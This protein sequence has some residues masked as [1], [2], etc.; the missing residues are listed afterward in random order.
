MLNILISLAILLVSCITLVLAR[1]SAISNVEQT[2]RGRLK[3]ANYGNEDAKFTF[4]IFRARRAGGWISLLT[5][6]RSGQLL[7]DFK[8]EGNE[9]D[10]NYEIDTVEFDRLAERVG[11]EASFEIA[12]VEDRD[13]DSRPG[14]QVH[15]SITLETLH[16]EKAYDFLA[17][18]ENVV[19][20][21]SGA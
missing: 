2:L 10:E 3:H 6:G 12:E 7:V 21:P 16:Q 13:V 18:L 15:G 19:I 20:A 17:G 1:M 9:V 5:P 4:K 14:K 11:I 8:I